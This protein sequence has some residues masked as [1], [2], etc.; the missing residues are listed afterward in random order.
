MFY[1]PASNGYF[2]A[3]GAH[4][5]RGRAF[6]NSDLADRPKVVIVNDTMARQYW[7]NED[8][9]GKRISNPGPHKEWYEVVGVVNDMGFP[10]DLGEPYT[11]YQAFVPLAQSAP[12]YLTIAL[13]TSATPEAI[14]NDLRTT[15]AGLDPSLPVY[16][17]R[18]A[19]NATDLRL[20]N[21]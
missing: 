3:Y 16:T 10:G 8:P 11:R 17:V 4:L 6:N 9:I 1:E 13:R 20:G 14:G 7:P 15:V 12:A 21:I 5:L 19:R 18:T 2:D